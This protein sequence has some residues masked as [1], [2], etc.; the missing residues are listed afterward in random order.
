M[1]KQLL[2]TFATF[3]FVC[4]LSAQSFELSGQIRPRAEY[5][6]GYK[7]LIGDNMDAAFAVSQRTR[8]NL[9]M[10]SKKV[11]VLISLQNVRVWGDAATGNRSDVNGTML[12]QAWGEYFLNEKLSVKAGRQTII[13]DDQRLFGNSDWN[14][15][16]RSH[17]ALLLKYSASAKNTLQAG[18]VYNQ[19]SEKD[20]GTF[21]SLNKNYKALQ[22]LYLHLENEKNLGIS[23]LVANVGMPYSQTVGNSTVQKIAYS[24]TLGPVITYT[25]KKWK[26]FASVY[27]QGGKDLKNID[28][29][30]WFASADINYKFSNQLH[31]GLGLQYLSGNDQVNTDSKDHEFTTLFG[32]GHR[33]N[34]WMDYFYSSSSHGGVGLVDLYLPAIYKNGKFQSEFQFHAYWSAA[35]VKN[36]TNPAYSMDSFLGLEPGIMFSYMLSD[37]LTIS[38]GYSQMFGTATL[39]ALKGGNHNLTQN[40][41]W[42]MM[43]FN[44]VFLKTSK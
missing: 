29:T 3:L 22:Y 12:Y 10:S 9:D 23:F 17:D 44:P 32:T 4:A 7:S 2:L 30:A 16:A 8:L 40:W 36:K 18:F 6:H 21:Y 34:G 26:I 39:E 35:S 28:K 27:Y 13:Y 38:G 41:S 43:T 19:S 31:S 33:Y 1:L 5:K 14:Q 15:Q 25:P 42:I 24:H 37:D 11:K 20:T